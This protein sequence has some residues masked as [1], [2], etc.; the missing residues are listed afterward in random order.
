MQAMNKGERTETKKNKK[1]KKTENEN[2]KTESEQIGNEAN[3][4]MEKAIEMKIKESIPEKIISLFQNYISKIIDY[5]T[6]IFKHY[7][8]G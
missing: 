3:I 6:P 2:I 4:E 5:L 7:Q 8:K 1:S